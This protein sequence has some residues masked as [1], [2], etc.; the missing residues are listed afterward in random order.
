VGNLIAAAGLLIGIGDGRQ[1]KGYFNFGQFEVVNR[2]DPKFLRIIKNGGIETQDEAIAAPE[3]YDDG[4]TEQLWNLYLERI[5]AKHSRQPVR[6]KDDG[7]ETDARS[8][9]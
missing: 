4:E 7:K 2:N 9:H 8:A 1:G 6:S 5:A 3:M